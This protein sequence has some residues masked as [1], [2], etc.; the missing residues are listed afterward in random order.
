MDI[1]RARTMQDWLEIR[2]ICCLTGDAGR[3]VSEDR[4]SFFAE[5]WIGP[6]ERLERD[7]TFVARADGRVAGYLTGCPA[8]L[9]FIARKLLLHDARLAASALL[10]RAHR[11]QD[12]DKFLRRF[13]FV[14]PAPARR[15]GLGFYRKLL[16]SHPAHLHVNVDEPYRS[17]G[18]GGRLIE[19]YVEA[20]RAEKV[21][22]VHLLCGDR[23]VEF[24]RRLGFVERASVDAAGAKVHCM[25]R[26]LR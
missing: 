17:A 15:F 19:A 9:P 3:P 14:E 4:R 8:S 12:S 10:G 5:Q 24:Y 26:D 23:P 13:F 7:W 11:T 22:G 25:V 21:E 20:L 18:V 6:Y 1:D 2:R 16:K